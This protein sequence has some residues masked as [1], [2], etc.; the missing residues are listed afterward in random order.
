MWNRVSWLTAFK[1]STTFKQGQRFSTH[2]CMCV[3]LCDS[4]WT[5][6]NF[7]IPVGVRLYENRI[8][9]CS[10]WGSRSNENF[11]NEFMFH[12]IRFLQSN[13]IKIIGYENKILASYWK[14][15]FSWKHEN[16][17]FIIKHFCAAQRCW[18]W[19]DEK[20]RGLIWRGWCEVQFCHT[21]NLI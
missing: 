3:C 5:L 21:Y 9:S 11:I 12:V 14:A 7:V 18:F 8:L 19:D 2:I 20:E 17:V 1:L 6:W 4:S 15:Q 16:S 10:M 13:R